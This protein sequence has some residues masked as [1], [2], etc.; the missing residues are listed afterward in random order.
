MVAALGLGLAVSQPA[1]AVIVSS[2]LNTDF[3]GTL[4][5]TGFPTISINDNDGTGAVHVILNN[6]GLAPAD[7]FTSDWWFNFSGD[8]TQLTFS[9]FTTSG[10]DGVLLPPDIDTCN[11]CTDAQFRPDGDGFFDVWLE[12]ST[13]GAGG[14]VQRFEAGEIVEFDITLAGI[15]ADNFNLQSIDGPGDTSNDHWCA[16]THA[17][18]LPDDPGEGSDFLGGQCDRF[19]PAGNGAPEPG[20]LLLLGATALGAGLVGRRRMRRG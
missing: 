2:T 16:A 17:Q 11:N 10:G 15:T 7:A 5:A 14:G 19:P 1:S 12:F 13:S 4:D 8:A 20:T 18:G 9:N 6:T 3:S